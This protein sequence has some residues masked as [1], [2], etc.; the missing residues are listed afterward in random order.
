V[1][2]HHGQVALALA[3]GDLVEVFT[4][5]QATCCSKAKVKREP[6]RAQGTEQMTTPCSLQLTRGASASSQA[7][8]VP[9]S[10]ARQ[11]RRPSRGRT[12]APGARRR[13]SDHAP[14]GAV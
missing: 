6:W 7:I 4:A 1:V 11:R 12:P 8:V 5:S 14:D 13:R 2:D 9:R 10:S 3:V